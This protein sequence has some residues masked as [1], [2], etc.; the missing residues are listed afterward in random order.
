M[1]DERELEIEEGGIKQHTRLIIVIVAVFMLIAVVGGA[2]LFLNGD[3]STES[4]SLD[5]PVA[6]SSENS[7]QKKEGLAEIGSALY[8]GMPRPLVFNVPGSKKERL[9]QIKV[10]LLVRGDD[11][12]EAAKRHIP[13]IENTLSRVFSASNADDLSTTAGKEALRQNA[14]SAVQN[15]LMEIEGIKVIERVLFTGFVMQ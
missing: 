13:L 14:L 15:A 5:E 11:N 7:E 1:A 9:V 10:Q 12:E 3:S 2:F 8:V 6:Q 4:V